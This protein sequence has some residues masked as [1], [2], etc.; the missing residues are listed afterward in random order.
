MSK[1]NKTRMFKIAMGFVRLFEITGWLHQMAEHQPS[2]Y[3]YI[4]I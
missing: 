2:A 4:S 1:T 3:I